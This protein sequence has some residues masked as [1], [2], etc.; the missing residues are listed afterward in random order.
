L[1]TAPDAMERIVN[2]EPSL[3]WP[4]RPSPATQSSSPTAW[5]D[6]HAEDSTMS[7]LAAPSKRWMPAP[8]AHVPAS[9]AS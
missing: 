8:T 3:A 7:Q 1:S 4:T 9:S 6:V 2:V 5:I